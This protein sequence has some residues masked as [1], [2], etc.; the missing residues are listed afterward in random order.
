MKVFIIILLLGVVGFGKAF[1]ED[2]IPLKFQYFIEPPI[3]SPYSALVQT[4]WITQKLDHFNSYDSR[5]FQMRYFE[6]SEFLQ[7]GGPIFIYV[8]GEWSITPGWVQS[9]HM[10]DMARQLNGTMYYTEHRYYGYSIPTTS[11]SVSNLKY[12][13]VD[14]ALA[15]LAYFIT[16]EKSKNPKLRNSGVI[17][18]GASYSATMVSWFRKK[19]PHLANGAWASSAPLFAKVDFIEYKEVMSDA[20]RTIGGEKCAS[21]INNGFKA[22]DYLID[23]NQAKKLEVLLNL[24]EPLDLQNKMNIWS[25]MS[26]LSNYFARMVQYYKGIEIEGICDQVLRETGDDLTAFTS[27]LRNKY[28]RCLSADHKAIVDY[29]KQTSLGHGAN[30]GSRQWMYQTCA[31]FGW[32]QTSNSPRNIFGKNYPVDY[33]TQYCSDIFSAAFNKTTIEN[34]IRRTNQIYGGFNPFF[35]NVYSTH[36]QWDPW[37][38]MGIKTDLNSRTPVSVIPGVAHCA[39]LYSIASSDSA[40]M[41]AVKNKIFSLVKTWLGL[42]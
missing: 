29:M 6:N 25:L 22:I 3:V 38:P 42:Q 16:Q 34:N 30:S 15:D 41:K 14:Q 32:Y 33:Y 28:R 21:R 9:G 31:E 19:Y 39:D 4:K 27:F 18:V 8:G 36:G 37:R 24:C 12:L 1:Y 23:T 13:S 17:L 26:D 7:T 40:E 35:T 10:Y 11:T 20:F 2:E 5:T